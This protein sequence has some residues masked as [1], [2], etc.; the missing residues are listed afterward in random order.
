MALKTSS[1]IPA[2]FSPSLTQL[3]IGWSGKGNNY[4]VLA[5]PFLCPTRNLLIPKFGK[6][7]LIPK[8]EFYTYNSPLVFT[9]QEWD[10]TTGSIPMYHLASRTNNLYAEEAKPVKV[11]SGALALVTSQMDKA[12]DVYYFSLF[13][14]VANY[15][16]S[17]ALSAA[18]S[19]QWD[20][21]SGAPITDMK[22]LRDNCYANSGHY[23]NTYVFAG[24]VWAK[25]ETNAQMLAA[26]P[27]T[28][29]QVVTDEIIKAL[30]KI[31]PTDTIAIFDAKKALTADGALENMWSGI[32]IAAYISNRPI[33]NPIFPNIQESF[34][35]DWV[36][37]GYPKVFSWAESPLADIVARFESDQP[38]ILM[39]ECGAILYETA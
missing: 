11:K 21:A 31:K 20:Q 29:P 7:M 6:E 12:N 1:G 8:R 16:Y 30:L 22:L 18:A 32:V 13:G 23:P 5:P 28:A 19:R 37:E 9:T 35:V 39:K 36:Y 17:L 34:S 24:D 26:V 4:R 27:G 14:N 3:A 15:S 2:Q 10:T 25:L 33:D 38:A